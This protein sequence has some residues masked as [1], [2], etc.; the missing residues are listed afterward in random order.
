MTEY[1]K[2]SEF[3]D[4]S[5]LYKQSF[6]AEDIGKCLYKIH[7]DSIRLRHFLGID[8]ENKIETILSDHKGHSLHEFID[9]NKP[10]WPIIDFD[11][12]W[13]M[14]DSIEP[15]LTDK[16]HLSALLQKCVKIYFQTGI[17]KL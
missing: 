11:L 17:V 16:I 9:G 5:A 13:K 10:F 4:I 12:S 15:K 8:N 6:K 3:F 14:Y 1:L 2:L 7:D